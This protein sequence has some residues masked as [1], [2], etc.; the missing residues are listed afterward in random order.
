MSDFAPDLHTDFGYGSLY[1]RFIAKLDREDA[2]GCVLWG[3]GA[4]NKG[5]GRIRYQGEMLGAPRV[6]FFIANG[7]F[8]DRLHVLHSCDTPACVEPSHLSLGTAADN[9]R[10][11]EERGRGH[12]RKGEAA[13]PSKLTEAQVLDIYARAHAG[14]NQ[15]D[16]ANDYGICASNVSAIK[17]GQ[18]WSHITQGLNNNAAQEAA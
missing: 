4:G 8:D 17:T 2:N 3:G 14:E 10:D 11:R 12:E 1:A 7:E 16:I 15:S 5:R 18:N 13:G 9:A 6:A